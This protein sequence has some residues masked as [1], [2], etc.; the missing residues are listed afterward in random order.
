VCIYSSGS[1][2]AQKLL[3]AHTDA[4]NP[5]LTALLSSYYDTVNA[6]PK[7]DP[8]SYAAIA[9][10][11]DI[12]PGDWIFLSDNV[13]EVVA[14]KEAGM[15]STVLIRPGNAPLTSQERSAH[16]AVETFDGLGF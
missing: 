9:A 15:E 6:G 10:A 13:K 11:E 1:V 3:F 4:P 14:A 8:S 2:A 5:D 7:Q 16:K 12:P